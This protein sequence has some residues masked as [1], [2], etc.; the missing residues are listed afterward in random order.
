MVL[1]ELS[2]K[3][4]GSF[5]ATRRKLENW[6]Y[7]VGVRGM[8]DPRVIHQANQVELDAIRA[9]EL[10]LVPGFTAREL[11]RIVAGVLP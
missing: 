8:C 9:M 4:W 6:V 7:G 10:R 3:E 1:Q 11:I 5:R 2:L